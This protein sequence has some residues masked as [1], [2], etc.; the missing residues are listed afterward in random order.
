MNAQA[1]T[2][3]AEATTAM[4]N[5]LMGSVAGSEQIVEDEAEVVVPHLDPEAEE[6]VETKEALERPDWFP[7][8]F[9]NEDGFELEK[10]T[11]SYEELE[12]AFTQGKHKAPEKFD[13]K[14]LDDAGFSNEDPIVDA[15]LGWAKKFGLN[16]VAFD[17]LATS[18]ASIGG[19]TN[20]QIQNDYETELKSLGK[21]AN[22]I[23]QSN[24]NWSDGLLRKGVITDAQREE[25]NSWGG[26]AEGQRLLQTVRSLTGDMTPLPNIAVSEAAMTDSDF[27]D[28]IDTMMADPRY[29]SDAKFSNDVDSKIYKRRGESFPG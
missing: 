9:W 3:E 14:V 1:E 8:K 27:Q 23:I 17:E 15:Y 4:P 18:I 6:V 11:K 7:E 16:Q 28:E 21:N 12:K 20:Q 2:K 13:T 24:V 25:M 26:T 10:M 5:G 19:E 22:E 29:G